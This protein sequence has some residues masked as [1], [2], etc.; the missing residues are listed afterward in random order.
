MESGKSG[1]WSAW[2]RPL[3]ALLPQMK[4]T[5]VTGGGAFLNGRVWDT[6]ILFAMH[7]TLLYKTESNNLKKMDGKKIGGG[8]GKERCKE[9]DLLP[10]LHA[11]GLR[12]GWEQQNAAPGVGGG[13]GGPPPPV[14]GSLCRPWGWFGWSRSCKVGGCGRA[15]DRW[16]AGPGHRLGQRYGT[17][18][19]AV[20]CPGRRGMG[21]ERRCFSS[22]FRYIFAP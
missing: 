21:R 1:L 3:A 14:V 10:D 19:S 4:S 13:E 7:V 16:A 5:Y 17:G 11:R 8:G 6:F 18:F 9:A 12:W 22:A 2:R 20:G 15:L